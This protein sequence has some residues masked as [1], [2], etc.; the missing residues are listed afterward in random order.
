[1]KNGTIV[2]EIKDLF[3][4][5]KKEGRALRFYTLELT[6]TETMYN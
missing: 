2:R 6:T 1:M 3:Q 5:W 4:V